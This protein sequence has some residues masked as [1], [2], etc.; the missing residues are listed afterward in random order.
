MPLNSCCDPCTEGQVN[1]H[2]KRRRE[3]LDELLDLDS[4]KKPKTKHNTLSSFRFHDDMSGSSMPQLQ[5]SSTERRTQKRPRVPDSMKA[6]GFTK[7]Q[8][9]DLEIL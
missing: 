9:N 2:M 3:A 8:V 1:K 4:V 6:A 7:T 5:G